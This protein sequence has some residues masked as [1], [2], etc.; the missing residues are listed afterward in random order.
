MKAAKIAPSFDSRL[1]LKAFLDWMADI[2]HYFE[3]Y[4]MSVER[5]VRLAKM[6]LVG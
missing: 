3:R 4:K 1:D 5:H 6:K 2:D